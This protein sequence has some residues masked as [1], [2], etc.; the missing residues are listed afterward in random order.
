[1]HLKIQYFITM[2]IWK[3]Q[4]GFVQSG[5]ENS[6][7]GD[8]TASGA[9]CSSDLMRKSFGTGMLWHLAL[10]I[11]NDEINVRTVAFDTPLFLREDVALHH[12]SLEAVLCHWEAPCFGRGFI[13]PLLMDLF[14]LIISISGR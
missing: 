2:V 12:L 1:M 9:A 6:Q 11:C 7:G 8:S 14:H 5:V 3:L 4:L 13:Q 10:V